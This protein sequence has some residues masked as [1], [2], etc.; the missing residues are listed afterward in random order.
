M[1]DR[2]SKERIFKN[3]RVEEA[4]FNKKYSIVKQDSKVLCVATWYSA[5]CI[6]QSLSW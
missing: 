3:R 5:V 1:F 4:C 6:G 2:A